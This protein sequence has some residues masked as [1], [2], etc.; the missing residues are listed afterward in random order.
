[1]KCG[2]EFFLSGRKKKENGKAKMENG[3]AGYVI[4]SSL[5]SE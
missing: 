4:N 2:K 5:R 1:M 3:K